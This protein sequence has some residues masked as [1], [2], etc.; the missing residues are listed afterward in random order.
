MKEVISK[1]LFAY[2]I[3]FG[4]LFVVSENKR[5]T[6][7]TLDSNGL[8]NDKMRKYSLFRR[9][10]RTIC[11]SLKNSVQNTVSPFKFLAAENITREDLSGK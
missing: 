9:S 3:N 1:V 11:D 10:M 5:A 7:R 4:S 8:T 6:A 2:L